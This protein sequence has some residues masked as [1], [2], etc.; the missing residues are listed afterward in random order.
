ML[1]HTSAYHTLPYCSLSYNALSHVTTLYYTIPYVA[2]LYYTLQ[3]L[4][5]P[6]HASS[7]LTM[8]YHSSKLK[9]FLF[10]VTSKTDH[11]YSPFTIDLKF[12]NFF[13][14]LSNRRALS[15]IS[16]AIKLKKFLPKEYPFMQIFQYFF[17]FCLSLISFANFARVGP[18]FYNFS[19]VGGLPRPGP[20]PRKLM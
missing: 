16:L 15:S 7:Y 4:T 2:I 5:I 9:A 11:Q 14:F 13:K 17:L 1:Y 10:K 12:V 3:Y 8:P 6:C 20:P 19:K 18:I